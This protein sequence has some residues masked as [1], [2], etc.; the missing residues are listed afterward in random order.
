[1]SLLVIVKGMLEEK[2]I[3]SILLTNEFAGGLDIT[4]IDN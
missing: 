4:C 3:V 1:M 2:R